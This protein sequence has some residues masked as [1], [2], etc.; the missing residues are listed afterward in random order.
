MALNGI[1]ENINIDWYPDRNSQMPIYEQIVKYV[2][3]KVSSGEWTVGM[4]MPSQR[5]LAHKWG[6]NRSTVVTAMDELASYGIIECGYGGGTRI[7]GNTWSVLMSEQGADWNRYIR[8]GE[9]QANLSTI[10][11]INKLEFDDYIRLGTGEP[12]PKLFPSEMM[13]DIMVELSGNMI[14]LNYLEP[15]GLRKLREVLSV[16]L[17]KEGIYAP[18]SCILITSGSLQALQLISICMLKRGST[19][20][21]EA[22]SYLKSL[23]I[24]QSAGMNIEGIPMDEEG[25]RYEAIAKHIKGFSRKDYDHMLYTIPTF[26]NPT[27]ILMSEMRR[28][29]LFSFCQDYRLPV[30]E[31][32]AYSQIWFDR[33]PP[34]S[35]KARDRNGMVLYLGTLSKS[36]APGLRI[37]WIVGPESVVQ[38]L[39][40]VKMQID[41]GASSLSQLVA[42]RFLETGMYDEYLTEYRVEMKKRRDNALK[43]MEKYMSGKAE[44]RQPEGGFYI[45][46]TLKGNVSTDQL[47]RKALSQNI[48]LNPGNIYDFASNK[49][50][51]ISYAYEDPENFEKGIKTVSELI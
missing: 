48:L 10:Q 19:V 12:D 44:W 50:L 20:F 30:I 25:I 28:E 40:D 33:K 26:Q 8:A 49:A 35:L 7:A 14:S 27:G 18:P 3:R 45:W 24:F 39:G 15:L 38:R 43:A 2:C 37:G 46:T 42:A 9:F 41:Y 16:R 31:D 4:K 6:V 34:L 36:L 13:K 21:A 51:R 22:P 23:Q 5:E 29:E 47:F 32:S 1:V 17:E 11:I